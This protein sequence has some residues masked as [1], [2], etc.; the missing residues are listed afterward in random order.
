MN[1][2]F[3]AVQTAYNKYIIEATRSYGR[4]PTMELRSV[5]A[6]LVKELVDAPSGDEHWLWT[7]IMP[8]GVILQHQN[9]KTLVHWV[10]NELTIELDF[11]ELCS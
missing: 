10:Q 9:I 5:E 3:E 7:A 2:R 8:S 6:E 1:T 4:G 11:N